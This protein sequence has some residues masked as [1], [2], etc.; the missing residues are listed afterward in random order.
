MRPLE[1]PSEGEAPR[2]D[3]PSLGSSSGLLETLLPAMT[4]VTD[5]TAHY[6]V[7]LAMTTRERELIIQDAINAAGQEDRD[8]APLNDNDNDD[9]AEPPY[10]NAHLASL[11]WAMRRARQDEDELDSDDDQGTLFSRSVASGHDARS[12]R[13]RR[14][15][16]EAG[17][18]EGDAVEVPRELAGSGPIRATRRSLTRPRDMTEVL[19]AAGRPSYE[20]PDEVEWR[21]RVEGVRLRRASANASFL[22]MAAQPNAGQ[23]VLQL[24]CVGCRTRVCCR[25]IEAKV[26]HGQPPYSP[27]D[28]ARRTRLTRCVVTPLLIRTGGANLAQTLYQRLSTSAR[29]GRH[30]RTARARPA[31][32]PDL[33]RL[34]ALELLRLCEGQGRLSRMVHWAT[35]SSVRSGSVLHSGSHLGYFII[36]PCAL[37]LRDVNGGHVFL[38]S[39]KTVFVSLRPLSAHALPLPGA[40]T[41][42]PGI[43]PERRTDCMTWASG[44][45]PSRAADYAAGLVGDPVNW[46]IGSS[47]PAAT[48]EVPG[49]APLLSAGPSQGSRLPC[50]AF[51]LGFRTNSQSDHPRR[52]AR[53]GPP[54]GLALRPATVYG[55][56]FG[57]LQRCPLSILGHPRRPFEHDR[58]H[59]HRPAHPPNAAP[60]R[61]GRPRRPRLP[62][63]V[64]TRRVRLAVTVSSARHRTAGPTSRS[65]CG[66]RREVGRTLT[67]RNVRL[68]C[69]SSR[70]P[71]RPDPRAGRTNL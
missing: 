64:G 7:P 35:T 14:P 8:A 4:P 6:Y 11:R 17:D 20:S 63:G 53:Q 34:A 55:P 10:L 61:P 69:T 12:R 9:A 31:R 29:L 47:S 46:L 52:L 51:A 66:G 57:N 70:E 21:Q 32:G 33:G 28:G 26:V 62:C 67:G 45:L 18:V 42:A 37:C 54:A 36:T 25:A 56:P 49:L 23:P 41:D 40:D 50:E 39:P 3:P 48:V 71:D 13:R 38:W 24:E 65:V 60:L 30:P 19:T 44:S 68:A 16:A 58:R 15:V 59:R 27:R 43:V 2:G 22:A 5:S 1:S